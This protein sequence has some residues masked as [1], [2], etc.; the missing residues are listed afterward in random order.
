MKRVLIGILAAIGGIF[1]VLVAAVL[2]T[3]DE[4]PKDVVVVDAL[5]ILKDGAMKVYKLDPGSY[6]V[7][8]TASN[9]GAQVRW[10]G[11][12]CGSSGQVTSL[13]TACSLDRTGQLLIENPTE[14]GQ[15]ASTSVTVKVT[16][17][18]REL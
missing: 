3:Q 17:L 9:D 4:E 15:G 8:L 1:L 14:Y 2:V 5:E 13:D 10:I 12:N 16:K 18:G 11:A 7:E 6:K